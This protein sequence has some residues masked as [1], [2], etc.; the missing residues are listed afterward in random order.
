MNEQ[1]LNQKF[2]VFE[3]QIIQLQDQIRTIDQATYDMQLI[4]HGLD[5]LRGKEGEEI[6]APIGRGIFVKAKLLSE[7]LTVDIG[8]Q[9][10]VKK[11]IPEAKELIESQSKKFK[12]VKKEL[13]ENLEKINQEIT[14]IMSEHQAS[15]SQ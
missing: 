9:N 3:R 1:E 11:T 4:T 6:M 14:K 15:Q 12:D 10:F 7:D 8:G 5:D 2:Q 13:E